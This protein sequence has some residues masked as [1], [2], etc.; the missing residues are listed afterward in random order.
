LRKLFSF[1]LFVLILSAAFG[2]K[3]QF[4]FTAAENGTLPTGLS[5]TNI[6]CS[7]TPYSSVSEVPV[8]HAGGD[9]YVMKLNA[10][11]WIN[12]EVFPSNLKEYSNSSVSAWVYFDFDTTKYS[13]ERDYS[14]FVRAKKNPTSLYFGYWMYVS[15]NASWHGVQMPAYCCYM[16]SNGNTVGT[17]GTHEYTTGW[18][19]MTLTA[20]GDQIKAYVDGNLEVSITDSNYSSGIYGMSY[21]DTN[22]NSAGAFDNMVFESSDFVPVELSD[23]SSN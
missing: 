9:G 11:L 20:D 22:Y 5:T 16:V 21:L 14:L 4:D 13:S 10:N 7:V 2:F 17:C 1:L 6:A 12:N 19:Q 3:Q 8:D 18:H 15:I 23:F